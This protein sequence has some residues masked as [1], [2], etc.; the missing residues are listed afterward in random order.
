MKK[1]V[2]EAETALQNAE[3]K[4]T[5]LRVLLRALR[6]FTDVKELT[7]ELVNTRIKRIE[8]HSP[9]EKWSRGKVKVDIYFTAVG[10]IDLPTEKK[11]KKLM[12]KAPAQKPA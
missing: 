10:L 11:L 7:P 5:D 8:V 3:Q 9:E 2:S 6:E 12:A 1:A 4:K